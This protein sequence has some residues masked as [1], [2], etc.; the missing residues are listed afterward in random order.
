MFG[1]FICD[2]K[3]RKKKMNYV[4]NNSEDIGCYIMQ[5]MFRSLHHVIHKNAF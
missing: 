3:I 5:D 4:R 2:N 1:S